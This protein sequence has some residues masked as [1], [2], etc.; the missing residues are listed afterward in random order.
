MRL[1][2]IAVPEEDILALDTLLQQ[3]NITVLDEK[4]D[5]IEV[6]L[7]EFEPDE[8]ETTLEEDLLIIQQLERELDE[9]IWKLHHFAG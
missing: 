3:T 8:A 5:S 1:I 7:F 6:L 4:D 9:E 2:T